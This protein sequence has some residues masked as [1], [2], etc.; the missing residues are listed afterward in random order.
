MVGTKQLCESLLQHEVCKKNKKEQV[1]TAGDQV[2]P[3]VYCFV[4]HHLETSHALLDRVRF[5]HIPIKDKLVVLLPL[6]KLCPVD[7][8]YLISILL[9]GHC[10]D[11]YAAGSSLS[12]HDV[13]LDVIQI[14]DGHDCTAA[15]AD[16]AAS[17]GSRTHWG[18]V[19]C[20]GGMITTFVHKL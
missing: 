4:V 8:L 2:C 14:M 15:V 12:V 11:N 9:L 17:S 10:S 6:T 16:C 20:F 7:D 5:L 18:D 19:C 13:Y 1:Y 3:D